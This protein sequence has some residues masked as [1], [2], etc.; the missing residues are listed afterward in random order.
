MGYVNIFKTD[1]EQPGIRTAHN[2][3]ESAVRGTGVYSLINN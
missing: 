3:L 2:L 1:T